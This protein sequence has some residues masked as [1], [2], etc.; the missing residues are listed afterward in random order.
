MGDGLG[1]VRARRT[2]L[3]FGKVGSAAVDFALPDAEGQTH[4]LA[5]Y[6]GHWLLMVFHRH[7]A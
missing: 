2:L 7:L 6:E 1:I 3:L 4:T 5:Q